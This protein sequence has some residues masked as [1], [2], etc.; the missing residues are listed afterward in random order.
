MLGVS[1]HGDQS[2]YDALVRLAQ[3]FNQRYPLIDGQGNFGSRDGDGAAAMRYTGRL[4]RIAS[5]LSPDRH[6]HGGLSAQLRRI[7]A[8][9][10]PAA[11]RLPFAL[12]SAPAGIAVGL[13]T[14]IPSHNLREVAGCL[15]RPGE[16]PEPCRQKSCWPDTRPPITRRRANH[17]QCGRHPRRLPQRARQPEGARAGRSKTW[18]AASGSWSSPSCR[19]ACRRKGAGRNRGH[20]QPQVKTGKKALTQEQQQLKTIHAGGARRCARRIEQGRAGAPGHRAPRQH[21]C[22]QQDLITALLAHTSLETSRPS[23]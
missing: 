17:Q 19:R 2:A 20:Q 9:A 10:L 14:E 8:G 6:G 18:R 4:A 1:P 11:A 3:D 12:N 21:A 16:K 13:A 22:E 7:D 5:L 23:T 15:Y